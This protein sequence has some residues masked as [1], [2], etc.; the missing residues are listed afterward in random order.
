VFEPADGNPISSAAVLLLT[1][2]SLEELTVWPNEGA[3]IE[4]IGDE[5]GR[6]MSVGPLRGV[7]RRRAL[8]EE[9][10]KKGKRKR[11]RRVAP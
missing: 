8:H 1:P 9:G 3:A 5:L 7:S 10:E 2:H 11:R 6:R 4:A